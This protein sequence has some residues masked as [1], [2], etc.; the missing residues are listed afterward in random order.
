MGKISERRK[1]KRYKVQD[2][3]FVFFG[4]EPA[5]A[6]KVLDI[7]R[8]GL[9]FTYLA[10]KSLT[11]GS[12]TLAL[13][14]T[15]RSFHCPALIGRTVLDFPIPKK[16]ITGKRRC[17]VEFEQLTQNQKSDIEHFIDCCTVGQE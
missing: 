8:Q 17:G 13:M 7:G 2:G 12:I 1:D 10:S 6:G 5:M 4:S 3:A 15:Q 14:S 11:S 9:G 16:S